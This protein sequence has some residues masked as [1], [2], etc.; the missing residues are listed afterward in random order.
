MKI[1]THLC[2]VFFIHK[3]FDLSIILIIGILLGDELWVN[4]I[5]KRKIYHGQKYFKDICDGIGKNIGKGGTFFKTCVN[6]AARLCIFI[7]ILLT[8][9]LSG[10]G[11]YSWVIL[12]MLVLI[13]QF[14]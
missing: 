13:L 7:L 14:V 5:I 11:F 12:I 2:K 6:P 4:H 9:L 3:I 1:L 10:I 8:L